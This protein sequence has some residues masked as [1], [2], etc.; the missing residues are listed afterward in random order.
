MADNESLIIM[1]SNGESGSPQTLCLPPEVIGN[2]ISI[3][4]EYMMPCVWWKLRSVCQSWKAEVERAFRTKYLTDTIIVFHQFT[5]VPVGEA[6]DATHLTF[7]FDRLSAS[8]DGDAI[9]AF[10]RARLDDPMKFEVLVNAASQRTPTAYQTFDSI[11]HQVTMAGIATS[12]PA[13]EGFELDSDRAEVSVLWKP[14]I[15]QLMGDELRLRRRASELAEA[16]LARATHEQAGGPYRIHKPRTL[17]PN[18]SLWMIQRH[19]SFIDEIA[20]VRESR[21]RKHYEECGAQ[22]ESIEAHDG[23]ASSPY[24]K[25]EKI[26]WVRIRFRSPAQYVEL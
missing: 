26:W 25:S 20:K 13:L 8:E 12:D 3:L 24:H 14:M 22:F 21:I 15:S 18:F 4:P 1:P 10:F 6:T 23:H 7:E 17:N 11:H 16:K 19:R 2:L 5:P 9:R